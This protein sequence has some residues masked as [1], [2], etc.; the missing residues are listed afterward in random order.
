MKNNKKG[1]AQKEGGA[2]NAEDS[3]AAA[4]QLKRLGKDGVKGAA[5]G[6]KKGDQSATHLDYEGAAKGGDKKGDQSATHR[7]YEGAGRMGYTQNFGAARQG[8]YAK[9]AAKVNS[10]MKGAAQTNERS[11]KYYPKGVSSEGELD[12]NDPR[13]EASWNP[14]KSPV[15]GV[16]D[17]TTAH[18]KLGFGDAFKSAKTRGHDK[19]AWRGKSYHTRTADEESKA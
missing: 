4:D 10:I 9:G 19:F 11:G 2:V 18:P 16:N 7:D 17:V 14:N 12:P 13:G 6:S 5:R 15:I 1:A 3:A 8:G